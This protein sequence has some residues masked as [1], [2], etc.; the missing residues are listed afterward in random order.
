V[1]RIFYAVENIEEISF[2]PFFTL[3]TLIR[4]F[5]PRSFEP[6]VHARFIILMITAETVKDIYE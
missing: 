2:A 3:G 5:F 4:Y 1:G 6:A